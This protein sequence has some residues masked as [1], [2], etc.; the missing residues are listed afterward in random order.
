MDARGFARD[1]ERWWN[2]RDLEPLLARYADDVVVRSPAAA[3]LLGDGVLPDGVL[4]DGVLHG[5]RA[6]REFWARGLAAV[7]H[8]RFAVVG[9]F[10][11]VGTVVLHHRD[12]DGR[13]GVDVFT[14]RDGYVVEVVGAAES[15]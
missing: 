6:V 2:D 3:R 12:Q 8:L 1:W 13:F 4:P 10:E 14:F 11:G 7:P 5:R 15:R 9:V